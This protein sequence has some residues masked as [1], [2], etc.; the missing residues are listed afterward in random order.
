MKR[1]EFIGYGST[2]LM[3]AACGTPV[4]FPKISDQQD[5][6]NPGIG[7]IRKSVPPIDITAYRGRHYQD[8]VP[9][10]LDLA[11]RA[12]IAVEGVLTQGCNP[13]Y[14]CEIY[15]QANYY[16]DPPV[17]YHSFHDYNGGQAKYLESLALLRQIAGSDVNLNV[18]QRMLEV[19]HRMIGPD[20][21]SYMAV[22]GR[23][24]ALFDDWNS[25]LRPTN[26]P[27]PAVEQ[28]FSLW[29]HGR[30]ILALAAWHT[31]EPGNKITHELMLQSALGVASIGVEK[32][33]M[34]YFPC[35]L[36][37]RT[38]DQTLA[39]GGTFGG[40]ASSPV[41]LSTALAK[42]AA[43][44]LQV[45]PAACC[46]A[47]TTMQGLARVLQLTGDERVAKLAGQL[48]HYVRQPFL[49]DGQMNRGWG[50]IH[51]NLFA[52]TG[53]LDYAVL[54]GDREL[55]QLCR[56]V[57]EHARSEGVPQLGFYPDGAF[58]Y[59]KKMVCSESCC[60]ADPLILAVKLSEYSVGDYWEDV[61]RSVRNHFAEAQRIT[62]DWPEDVVDL[63]EAAGHE[64]RYLGGY[65][66]KDLPHLTSIPGFMV[67]ENVHERMRGCFATFSS[68]N[69]WYP[70]WAGHVHLRMGVSACCTGNGTRAIFYAWR[71]ILTRRDDRLLV[72]LLLNRSSV[73]ADVNSHIPYAGQVDIRMKRSMRLMVR[74][75]E[76]VDRGAIDVT[77]N[78]KKRKFNW[79]GRYLDVGQVDRA[80]RVRLCF[81]IEERTQILD[82]PFGEHPKVT[83]TLRGNDVVDISPRGVNLPF[84]Q[85]E[86][87]RSGKTRWKKMMRF[88]P[89]GFFDV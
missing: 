43:E 16:W 46:D 14:D 26:M 72:N 34:L 28:L 4:R 6:H 74:I 78:Q 55:Q 59:G 23:P 35:E 87:F 76:W 9:D 73:W 39:A 33:D 18:D 61:D 2:G 21:L 81:P 57:Y 5:L 85:R 11:E 58:Q 3:M 62:T 49:P 75:P 69:D 10:T 44:G 8:T 42:A 60:V 32:G 45:K 50:H 15:Q 48:S 25:I 24:W 13:E 19:A 36:L 56:G 66:P 17:M 12:R 79:D 54:A 89:A 52:I 82:V 84:Y 51:S 31:R 70:G 77:V 65:D 86:H 83:V 47:G 30:A 63:P 40:E 64:E 7:Y 29:P 22:Q 53:L 41:P 68:I 67:R 27:P 71:G 38:T 88:E 37:Y 80:N 20:G 1:R